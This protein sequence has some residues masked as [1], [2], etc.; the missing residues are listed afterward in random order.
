M[1]SMATLP[2]LMTAEEF[3]ALPDAPDGQQ[4]ELVR[5]AIVM[6]PPSHAGHGSRSRRIDRFLDDFVRKH[7]LGRVSGEGA[8]RLFKQPDTVRPP[9]AA[10]IAYS[11]LPGGDFPDDDYPDAAPNL[12]VEVVSAHDREAD[13]AAKIDDYLSAGVD[14]VWIVRPKLRNVTVHRP[15]GDS[16][17]FSRGETLTSD[18]AGFPVDGFELS[19]ADIFA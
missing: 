2:G 17:T 7:D 13:I 8:Y 11:R 12:A 4:M 16:H 3:A 5:G 18:D 19:V 9:D 10:W 15:G 1:G 14:R 6:A